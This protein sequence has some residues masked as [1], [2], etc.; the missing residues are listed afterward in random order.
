M[1]Q[2]TSARRLDLAPEWVFHSVLGHDETPNLG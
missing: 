2:R 1:I